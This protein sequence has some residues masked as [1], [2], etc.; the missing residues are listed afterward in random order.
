MLYTEKSNSLSFEFKS[1]YW[2]EMAAMLPTNKKRLDFLWFFTSFVFVGLI[3][4]MF[5]MNIPVIV[6]NDTNYS[7]E[8]LNIQPETNKRS[9][10]IVERSIG[11]SNVK[12]ENNSNRQGQSTSQ[13]ELNGSSFENGSVPISCSNSYRYL[14]G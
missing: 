3:S 11:E 8:N 1:S 5:F 7:A 14:G 12:V 4:S 2:D 10:G 13:N 9:S 6:E